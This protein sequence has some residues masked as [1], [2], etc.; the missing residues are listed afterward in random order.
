MID[1]LLGPTRVL[2]QI[3]FLTFE[4]AFETC[5]NVTRS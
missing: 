4:Q 1:L 3:Q 2:E 5:L